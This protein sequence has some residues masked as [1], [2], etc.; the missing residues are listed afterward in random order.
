MG[1]AERGRRENDRGL[2]TGESMTDEGTG[3]GKCKEKEI[4]R[5]H[6]LEGCFRLLKM[7]PTDTSLNEHM[8]IGMSVT[9]S[10]IVEHFSL[11]KS[12]SCS[13]RFLI[14]F[15]QALSRPSGFDPRMTPL[16]PILFNRGQHGPFKPAQIIPLS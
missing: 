14:G 10:L 5:I 13:S 1:R 3:K 12:L 8:I 2:I 11:S 4:E 9:K 6:V 15:L 16:I 7:I